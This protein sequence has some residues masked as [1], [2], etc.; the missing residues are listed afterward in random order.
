MIKN[1]GE[2][3][4]TV[5]IIF[6]GVLVVSFITGNIVLLVEHKNKKDKKKS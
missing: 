4:N 1:R 2:T 6:I 5:Y 3:M